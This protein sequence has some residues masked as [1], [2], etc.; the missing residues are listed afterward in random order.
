[1]SSTNVMYGKKKIMT[2]TFEVSWF[3]HLLPN[4]SLMHYQP[5]MGYQ[6]RD[7]LDIVE[8]MH[9]FDCH[10]ILL[11]SSSLIDLVLAVNCK[12]LSQWAAN[13][14]TRTISLIFNVLIIVPLAAGCASVQRILSEFI[15]RY[16]SYCPTALEAAAQVVINMHNWSVPVISRG[17]DVDG[18]SFETAKNCVTG[19]VDICCTASVEA[20]SSSVI[21]GICSAVFLNAAAFFASSVDGKDIFQ[22]IDKDGLKMQGSGEIFI[23]LKQSILEEEIS[24]LLKLLK[25]KALCL[26]R[27]FFLC[28]KDLIAACFELFSTHAADGF[29]REG[30]YI[31]AQLCCVLNIDD[32]LN[33]TNV[34]DEGGEPEAST[35]CKGSDALK[36]DGEG[37]ESVGDQKSCLLGLVR[38]LFDLN[39]YISR[40]TSQAKNE[41]SDILIIW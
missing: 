32:G 33:S 40:T 24:P 39:L 2:S 37:A 36:E 14:F 5:P 16:R 9:T 35:D 6:K 23:Q 13:F 4:R 11:L 12:K 41:T 38:F 22:I 29:C 30:K 26:L 34:N 31:L 17:E 19:L 20:P 18:V 27:I 25:L 21:R 8:E 15:P 1:M 7:T 28:P 10:C 3:T